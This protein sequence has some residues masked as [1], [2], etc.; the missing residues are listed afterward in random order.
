MALSESIQN[1]AMAGDASPG[2]TACIPRDV[3]ASILLRLPASDLRRFRRVCKEWRDVISDPAFIDEHTV[4]GPR[5]L[6]HTIVFFPGYSRIHNDAED[7]D[8]GSGFLLD[9][10]W[11]LSATFTAGRSEDMIGT[12]NGLLCFLDRGQYECR[13]YCFGFDPRSRRYKIV[14]TGYHAEKVVHVC[15]VGGGESWRSVHAA[16]GAA[17]ETHRGPACADG[18]AYWSVTG[19]YWGTRIARLDLATEEV[20]WDWI[21]NLR[22]PD[23]AP[24]LSVT[25][26]SD[27]RV[28]VMTI[29]QYPKLEALFIGEGG[30]CW[31]HDV[32]EQQPLLRYPSPRQPLQ[33]GHLLME[34]LDRHGC[35]GLYANPIAPA[36]RDVGAAKLL[37][38]IGCREVEPAR[39]S[40]SGQHADNT[41]GLFVPVP[42]NHEQ[43]QAGKVRRVPHQAHSA[44]TF[45]YAP[46]VAPAPLAHYFGKL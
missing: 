28:C 23:P 9:E 35:G 46:P 26:G 6:T 14:H 34:H 4:H 3:L 27:A 5:A 2:V 32:L 31:V 40:S 10:Q 19:E 33:R 20:T 44:S 45:C 36:S 37:L 8:G 38:E 11:R 39:T 43:E 30:R 18:V 22:V 24:A 15:T 29:D 1:Q 21:R 13:A 12:C 16:G 25:A 42:F 17:G 7:T 41:R